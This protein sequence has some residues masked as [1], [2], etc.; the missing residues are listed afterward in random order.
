LRT[1]GNARFVEWLTNRLEVEAREYIDKIDGMGWHGGGGRARLSSNAR[2]PR[3]HTGCSAYESL[4]KV[5][6]ESQRLADPGQC[7]M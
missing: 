3:A 5:H 1:A 4:E 2:S 6:R 7:V